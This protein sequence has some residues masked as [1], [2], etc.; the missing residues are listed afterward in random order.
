M[1]AT[2]VLKDLA[3]I[4][5]SMLV[6]NKVLGIHTLPGFELLNVAIAK[7]GTCASGLYW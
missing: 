4:L 7:A 6:L 2:S 1:V 3:K 5:S